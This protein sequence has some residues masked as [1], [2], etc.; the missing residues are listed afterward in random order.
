MQLTD[1][2][3]SS[4]QAAAYSL[5]LASSQGK[6][7]AKISVVSKR[8]RHSFCKPLQEFW[9]NSSRHPQFL[10]VCHFGTICIC[11]LTTI[12][13][14]CGLHAVDS[15]IDPANV[16]AVARAAKAE[17]WTCDD[18]D[19]YAALTALLSSRYVLA[20]SFGVANPLA[21]EK[22]SEDPQVCKSR[23]LLYC[24]A[25][26]NESNIFILIFSPEPIFLWLDLSVDVV[27]SALEVD[28]ERVD[29]VFRAII[30]SE[31][32]CAATLQFHALL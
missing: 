1:R 9:R 4:N 3:L 7:P 27:Q 25:C 10:T 13:T 15:L 29:E 23:F 20:I 6:G 8:G 2:K 26:Q 31:N 16:L 32:A 14:R 12:R 21:S 19:K 28:F 30:G 11:C 24:V 22:A 5:K 18:S 17:Q